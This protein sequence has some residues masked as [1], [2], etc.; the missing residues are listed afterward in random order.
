MLL[1]QPLDYMDAVGHVAMRPYGIMGKVIFHTILKNLL[2]N[3]S[4]WVYM[5]LIHT[6][7]FH[8]VDGAELFHWY[9]VIMVHNLLFIM[10]TR[11]S[12]HAFPVK[13]KPHIDLTMYALLPSFSGL[14]ISWPICTYIISLQG[15]FKKS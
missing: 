8:V 6:P 10:L 14:K 11:I 7:I 15:A 12:R 5:W 2:T 9:D 1:H 4:T 13:N 3:L